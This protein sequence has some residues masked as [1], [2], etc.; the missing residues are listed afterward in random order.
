MAKRKNSQRVYKV[1]MLIL[2]ALII[3]GFTIPGFI[4]TE[5]DVQSI[6]VE[7]RLCQSDTDCYL[8]CDDVPVR[9]LCSQ[10]MCVRNVCGEYDLY[11]YITNAIQFSLSVIINSEQV[12]FSQNTNNKD[13]FVTF[14][15][16]TVSVFSS[17]ISLDHVL[18][19]VNVA[20]NA[21]CI[22]IRGET[23]C[24]DADTELSLFVND[25]LSYDYAQYVPEDGDVVRIVYK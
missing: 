5:E 10:N 16:P 22:F 8:T 11:P 12:D 21:E 18:E 2:L 24:R 19:K 4:N 3:I 6:N 14:D 9:V 1:G 17:G 20:L 15:G 7:P 25:E 23:L 13:N